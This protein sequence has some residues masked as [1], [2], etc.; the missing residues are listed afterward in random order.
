MLNDDD[1]HD[2]SSSMIMIIDHGRGV[3]SLSVFNKKKNR[4]KVLK[5][6]EHKN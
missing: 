3:F 2:C 6:N 4:K 5:I 1:D